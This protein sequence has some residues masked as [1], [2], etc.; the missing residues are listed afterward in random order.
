MCCLNITTNGHKRH[1]C[2]HGPGDAEKDM[3]HG[4]ISMVLKPSGTSTFGNQNQFW[5]S[6]TNRKPQYCNGGGL[7][8]LGIKQLQK[9]KTSSGNWAW[10]LLPLAQKQQQQKNKFHLLLVGK[11]PATSP[12]SFKLKDPTSIC[13]S[14]EEKRAHLS[15]SE[16]DSC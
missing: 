12:G 3:D 7:T 4:T 10:W 8:P 15:S 6:E 2:Q 13:L 1:S 14:L 11:Y 5:E 9:Q 16:I